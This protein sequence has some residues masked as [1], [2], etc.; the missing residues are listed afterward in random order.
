MWHLLA[1]RV[2]QCRHTLPKGR[3]VK[4]PCAS[5]R[6][7]PGK[8]YPGQR[9]SRRMSAQQTRH[10]GTW[11]PSPGRPCIQ[12]AFSFK[13]KWPHPCFPR[14]KSLPKA[15][16]WEDTSWIQ[17]EPCR[18]WTHNLTCWAVMQPMPMPC[19]FYL[20]KLCDHRGL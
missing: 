18:G 12:A 17:E 1:H 8:H 3:S 2:A 19:L 10:Q 4:P 6:G 13:T 20:H 5:A 9:S 15:A 16:L 7:L 11:C 14:G